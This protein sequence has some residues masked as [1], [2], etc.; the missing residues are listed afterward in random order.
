MDEIEIQRAMEQ[1][2]IERLALSGWLESAMVLD[3]RGIR[4][5]RWTPLGVQRCRE[6]HQML[7]EL[8]FC[9]GRR[10]SHRVGD[11]DILVDLIGDCI[12]HNGLG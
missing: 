4:S 12:A 7:V 11:Y 5:L 8:G 6:L 2:I 10:V 1:A 3:D 9:D